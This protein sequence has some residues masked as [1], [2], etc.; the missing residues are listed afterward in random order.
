MNKFIIPLITLVLFGTLNGYSEE[1]GAIEIQV[2]DWNGDISSPEGITVIIYQE[3]KLLFKEIELQTNPQTISEIPLEHNYS[4]EVIKHDINFPMSNKVFLDS[5]LKKIDLKIPLEGGMKFNVFHKDGYTPVENAKVTIKSS[6]GN[7]LVT[8]ITNDDGQTQR[9]WLQSTT[10]ENYYS[11]E[12]S[13]GENISFTRST[14]RN[15][16][17]IATDFKII[18][19]W[20]SII[21]ERIIVHL[22][23]DTTKNIADYSLFRIELQDKTNQLIKNTLFNHRG[24]AYFTNIHIGE[25][26]FKVFAKSNVLETEFKEWGSKQISL[27]GSQNTFEIFEQKTSKNLNCNCVAFRFDDIQDY[28]LNEI[29]KQVIKLFHEK[30]IPLTI[31]VIGGLIGSDIELIDLIKENLDSEYSGLE[32]ASH[33]WN[34]APLTSLSKEK[35]ESMIKLTN[36]VIAD[37]FGTT[38]TVFIP[39]ENLF[40]EDTINVLKENHFTHISSSVT[41]DLPPYSL[42]DSSFYRFPQG[43]QT[44]VLNSESNLWNIENRTKILD[45][46]TLS[47]DNNGFAVVMM[48][49]PE[50]AIIDNGIYR[51]VV[52]MEH[53]NE[54]ELLIDEIRNSE[55]KI[56][57]I[58]QINLD[59]TSNDKATST[60][61]IFKNCNCVAFSIAGIQDYWLNDVQLEIFNTF[62]KTNSDFTVGI[63]ANYFG[64][65]EKIVEF[66]TS[67]F[68]ENV[69]DIEV[70]NNGW[71]YE[72]FGNLRLN[73]QSSLIKQGN[74]KINNILGIQP[75]TFL[76]PFDSINEV[77]HYAL[78]Q[79]SI[80]SLNLNIL[81]VSP[82][83]NFEESKLYQI[84]YGITTGRYDQNL[85]RF[86]GVSQEEAFLTVKENIKNHDFVVIRLTP[87]EFSVFENGE[88]QNKVNS[89]QIQELE[90]LINKIKQEGY[91]IIPVYKIPLLMNNNII[92]IPDWVKSN[93]MWWSN[94]QISESD[95]TS[96][97]EFLIKKGII[98]VPQISNSQSNG[99]SGVPT[100]IKNNAGWWAAGQISDAEFVSGIQYLI[101]NGIIRI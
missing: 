72:E 77:T 34:N 71:V 96:G 36:G 78:E 50:F 98:I 65:D 48:H 43:A 89:T 31:G 4:F 24:E 99:N 86:V 20:P 54:L 2:K 87:Q 23:P 81:Y 46:V 28:Y 5:S 40:N 93:A 22:K 14:I 61:S 16:P 45:D 27:T 75:I 8:A 91:Q 64:S 41:Y 79:N 7:S 63:V 15:S 13:L 82:P 85:G 53:I 44:A 37:T 11:V 29:Q 92:E 32:I 35:Q 39:P 84:P 73:E 95:F 26:I 49:Q 6:N 3:N 19:P 60:T 12:I 97:L 69:P 18:T 38:P 25:Y 88:H 42:K 21:N 68:N 30:Q 100:W 62:M 80:T 90:L 47:I 74:E 1:F 66:F 67:N 52:N 10:L 9:Y 55:I 33:S 56:V 58:S 57:P 76:P 101:N 70:A 59:Q 51:N 17:G 94:N 83:Y